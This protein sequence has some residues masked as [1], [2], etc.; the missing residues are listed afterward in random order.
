MPPPSFRSTKKSDVFLLFVSKHESKFIDTD[1]LLPSHRD[2][3]N[4]LAVSITETGTESNKQSVDTTFPKYD[5]T[6]T[7]VMAGD[8]IKSKIDKTPTIAIIYK[9]YAITD[10][11]SDKNSPIQLIYNRR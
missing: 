2:T 3:Y 1:N 4:D 5:K 11:H 9:Q 8:I 10:G 7:L 6:V